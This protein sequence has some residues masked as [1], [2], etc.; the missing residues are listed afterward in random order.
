MN[1]VPFY[2]FLV[3]KTSLALAEVIYIMVITTFIYQKTA[4]ALIASLFPLLQAMANLVAG[5]VFP[6]VLRKLPFSKL[7]RGLPCIRAILLTLLLVSF[8]FITGNI[9][10]QLIH[11][12]IISFIGGLEKTILNSIIPKLV[13]KEHLVKANSSISVTTQSAQIAGYSFTGFAV[14]HWGHHPTLFF[15]AALIWMAVLCIFHTSKYTAQDEGIAQVNE[16]KW[17]LIKEGWAF[18]WH[19][20]TLRMV[21][22][23]DVIEGAAGSIWIGAITL[24]YVK[25]ALNRGEQWWGFINASYCIG[26][27]IGGLLTLLL[28]NFIQRYLIVSMAVGSLL[29][30]LF[31]LIYGLTS[32]PILALFLCVAMGPAYQIRDVAQ[33]TAFQLNIESQHLPKVYASQGILLSIVTGFSIFL[34]GFIADYIGVRAVYIFGSILI[35][36]SAI[37]SLSL[38]QAGKR[39]VH[40]EDF[41]S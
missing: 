39:K 36:I 26:S 10:V 27:I 23:M 12:L 24:V 22:L 25:E 5:L 15:T 16:S 11:V 34:M 9:Y 35:F 19:N 37:L 28:A 40:N 20:Q 1:K 8:E 32:V 17:D 14:I 41:K 18:L 31:T 30:S 3:G 38:V 2:S 4:S 33:Q 7:L 13:A 21:T 6:L 29:F